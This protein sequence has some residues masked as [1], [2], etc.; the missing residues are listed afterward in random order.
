VIV[1]LLMLGVGEI[2]HS[3]FS[4]VISGSTGVLLGKVREREGVRYRVFDLLHSGV[5]EA[6]CKQP[7]D[8]GGHIAMHGTS[9]CTMSFTGCSGAASAMDRGK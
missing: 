8:R 9:K 3:H 7:G 5:H 4:I 6:A 2:Q 1:L